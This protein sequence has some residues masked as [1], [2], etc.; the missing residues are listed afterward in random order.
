MNFFQKFYLTLEGVSGTWEN[1]VTNFQR[2]WFKAPQ[3]NFR[4]P[5]ETFSVSFSCLAI[6]NPGNGYSLIQIEFVSERRETIKTVYKCFDPIPGNK[7]L[8]IIFSRIIFWVFFDVT[9]VDNSNNVLQILRG[10][11]STTRAPSSS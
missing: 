7:T 4:L 6:A 11:G 3:I 9:L 2:F 8:Q 10:R 5:K 1:A